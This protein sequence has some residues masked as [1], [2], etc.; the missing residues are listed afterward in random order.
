MRLCSAVRSVSSSRAAAET[1]QSVWS[2]ACR[3][4]SRSAESR[5][6]CSPATRARRWASLHFQRNRVGGDAIVRR[7]DRHPLDDVAQLADVAGPGVA[8]EQRDGLVDRSSAAGSC[9]ARRTPHRK[10]GTSSAMSCRRSRSA[11]TRI[12]T[13]LRR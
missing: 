2:S 8:L 6:S 10:Y 5:T 7:E 9:C 4:R 1:F 3:M 13:T 12:G 11:G